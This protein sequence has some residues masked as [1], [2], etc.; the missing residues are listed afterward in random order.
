MPG[1]LS[2]IWMTAL[3]LMLLAV[4]T[5]AALIVARVRR[6][7]EERADPNRRDRISK[8]LLQFAMAGGEQPALA[9]SNAVERKILIETALDAAQIMRGPAK[10]RL[11][12]FLRDIGLDE[13]L[14]RQTRRGSLRDRLAALE[15]LRLFPDARTIATLRRAEHSRDLRV[16]LAALRTRTEVDAGPDMFGLMELAA[17]PGASKS[18]IMHELVAARAHVNLLEALR[19]LNSARGLPRALLIRAIGETGQREA[20]APLQVALHNPDP[21][22]RAAA[23]GAL[24][25][26]GFAAVADG[27]AR[28]TRDVDWRVRLKAAEAIGRL[29]LWKHANCLEPLLDDRVWWVR[30]RA[31]EALQ[32]LSDISVQDLNSVAETLSRRTHVDPT[33]AVQR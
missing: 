31:E 5:L 12:Q 16:W 10:E 19:A 20:L 24:G 30:F 26:L 27:L 32:K 6:E 14:R 28:A 3:V 9:V 22:T 13:R 7:H 29:G 4:G 1:P 21:E 33:R 23:A 11:V 2:L 18:Q 17:R 15:A 8:S 25:A